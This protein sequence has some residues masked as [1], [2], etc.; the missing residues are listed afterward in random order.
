MPLFFMLSGFVLALSDG[1][2][3][4][5]RMPCCGELCSPEPHESPRRM[6]GCAIRHGV[7]FARL[8]GA[9]DFLCRVGD[10]N[11]RPLMRSR[12]GG[13]GAREISWDFYR[14]R[15]ART[16][17]L[18]W[19]GNLMCVPLVYLSGNYLDPQ[20]VPSLPQSQAQ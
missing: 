16:L 1:A 4:Y 20:Y 13:F 11:R 9:T 12:E 8:R 5:G 10:A 14:R 17:P 15:A 2:T 19:L 7:E 18:Y 6:D 3:A